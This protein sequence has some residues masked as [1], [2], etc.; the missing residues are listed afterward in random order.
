L[1]IGAIL[2]AQEDTLEM[3]SIALVLAKTFVHFLC[4]ALLRNLR[5]LRNL[6]YAT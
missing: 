2:V 3:N 1:G 5:N 4:P 6:T